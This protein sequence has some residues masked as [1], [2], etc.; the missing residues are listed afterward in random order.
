MFWFVAVRAAQ[1]AGTS[2]TVGPIP[3]YCTTTGESTLLLD[4]RPQ[5]VRNANGSVAKVA[6]GQ[7]SVSPIPGTERLQ[8]RRAKA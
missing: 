8:P 1:A 6:A 5:Q 2:S 7:K 3:L 4:L